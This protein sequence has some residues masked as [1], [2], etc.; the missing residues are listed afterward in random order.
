[1]KRIPV[2]AALVCVLF[3]PAALEAAQPTDVRAFFRDGQTFITWKEDGAATGET[4][5]VYRSGR[6]LTTAGL[7]GAKM[8]LEVREGSCRF[9]EMFQKDGKSLLV[10]RKKQSPPW[11]IPRLCIEPVGDDNV[12]K[13]LAEGTGLM[14]RTVKEERCSSYYAVTA[15]TGGRE[16]RTVTAANSC[17]SLK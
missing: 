3:G 13:M 14:V 8:V 10:D 9:R 12:P 2:G 5:R 4:Y 16:A 6:P 1:M 17:G 11:V 15:V 7:A